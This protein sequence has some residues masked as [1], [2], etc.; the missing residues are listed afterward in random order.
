M[1]NT[2]FPK[3]DDKFTG[4]ITTLH[5]MVHIFLFKILYNKSKYIYKFN[6]TT[7]NR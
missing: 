6:K 2:L 4:F 5:N 1:A 3:F 7:E